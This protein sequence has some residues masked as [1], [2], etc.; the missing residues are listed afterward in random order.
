MVN[1]SHDDIKTQDNSLGNSLGAGIEHSPGNDQLIGKVKSCSKC[2]GLTD[3]VLLDQPRNKSKE[4]R[5]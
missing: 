1:P 4:K 2:Q 5:K 3:G